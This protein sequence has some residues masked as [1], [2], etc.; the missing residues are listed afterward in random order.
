[1]GKY[2]LAILAMAILAV[3]L[4]SYFDPS[5]QAER[6]AAAWEAQERARITIEQERAFAPVWTAAKIVAVALLG[7][8]AGLSIL[9]ASLF[10]ARRL[11]LVQPDAA[12]LLP[13][14]LIGFG[15]LADNSRLLLEAHHATEQARIETTITVQGKLLQQLLTQPVEQGRAVR[16]LEN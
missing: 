10:A 15:R 7:L 5:W 12:G 2:I 16:F 14:P 8:A 9:L 6:A 3:T 1:V 4:F 11:L 13:M